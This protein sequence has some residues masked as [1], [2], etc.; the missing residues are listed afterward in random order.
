MGFSSPDYALSALT[1]II[2]G[3]GAVIAVGQKG[4]L[5]CPY[6]GDIQ[7]A[8]LEADQSG[9]IVI[10]IWKDVYGNYPPTDADSITAAAPPTISGALKAKDT[11]LTGWTTQVFKDDILAFNVDSCAAI[12]RVT[13]TLHIKRS[14]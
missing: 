14:P 9:D 8:E 2:D 7:S 5:V 13:L 3:G 1:F 6:N 10:D 4:H 11:T 12:T